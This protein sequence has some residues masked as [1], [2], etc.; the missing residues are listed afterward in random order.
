MTGGASAVSHRSEILALAFDEATLRASQVVLEDVG[1]HTGEEEWGPAD[2]ALSHRLAESV[3]F[4][5]APVGQ[6]VP[7]DAAGLRRDIRL[8]IAR[9]RGAARAWAVGG[10]ATI[11]HLPLLMMFIPHCWVLT[12]VD[13]KTMRSSP[14]APELRY[15]LETVPAQADRVGWLDVAD[16][17]CRDVASALL[18]DWGGAQRLNPDHGVGR[19]GLAAARNR[20][21]ALHH[22]LLSNFEEGA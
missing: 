20:S 5:D 14:Y 22:N 6:R 16:P 15:A 12:F 3:C 8:L 18:R 2:I 10:L 21:A 17:D 7:I 19:L 13:S 9:R 11:E 1:V 4:P